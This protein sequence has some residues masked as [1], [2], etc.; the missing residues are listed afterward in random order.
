MDLAFPLAGTF[1]YLSYP[2]NGRTFIISHNLALHLYSVWT[3]CSLTYRVWQLGLVFNHTYYMGDPQ[4]ERLIF[5][6]YL[7]KY[8]EYLD[9]FILYAKGKQPIFL[10]KYHHVGAVICWHLAWSYK[11]DAVVMASISNSLIH[12]IMYLYYLLTFLKV[13]TRPV[14]QLITSSQIIQFFMGFSSFFWFPVET[15]ENKVVITL[16]LMYNTGLI[17]L[18]SQFMYKTYYLKDT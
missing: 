12:S 2:W 17:V 4:I 15:F 8:Y 10:Q 14:K 7:S 18:F 9:T 11:V 1:L 5:Y 3:F 16:F 13:N 6:F